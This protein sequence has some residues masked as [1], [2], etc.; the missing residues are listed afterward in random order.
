MSWYTEISAADC[1]WLSEFS[2]HKA[3]SFTA[4]KEVLVCEGDSPEGTVNY[5]RVKWKCPEA[6][7][8]A[9]KESDISLKALLRAPQDW[10]EDTW[11]VVSRS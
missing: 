6:L 2:L 7:S 3:A 1:D 5:K 4:L 9:F 11:R 8:I 10:V